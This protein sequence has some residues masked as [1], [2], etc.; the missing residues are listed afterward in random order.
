M[1]TLIVWGDGDNIIPVS[2][3]FAAHAALPNSRLEIIEGAGHFP[4][5]E[6]PARFSEILADFVKT[7][8]PSSF[9]AAEIRDLLQTM[10]PSPASAQS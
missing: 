4:H 10:T 6:D 7:T 2:H 9:T 5:V 3:A 1:P 8:Q